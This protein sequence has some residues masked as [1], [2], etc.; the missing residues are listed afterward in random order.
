MFRDGHFNEAVRKALERFEKTIQDIIGDHK[1]Q[2]QALMSKAFNKQNP[3]IPINALKTA[4]DESEQEGFMHLTMGAMA[5]M[6]NIY[7]HGDVEQ[8]SPMDAS[9]RLAFVS[10]LF[11]RV[12]RAIEERYRHE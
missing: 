12:D 4:N 2:G 1:S 10:L 7:S 11:K 8:M 6:R 3:R 5:G 9:E